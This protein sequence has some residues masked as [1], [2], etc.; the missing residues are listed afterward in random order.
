MSLL[1][2]FT[3][4]WGDSSWHSLVERIAISCTTQLQS[5]VGSAVHAMS[6]A[7]RYGYLRARS[8]ALVQRESRLHGANLSRLRYERLV[9]DVQERVVSLLV[10]Q[11]RQ[12][13]ALVARRAA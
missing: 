2:L 11:L 4:L 3:R 1:N 5:K 13:Q 12:P 10:E 9:H 8:T 7:E 6:A